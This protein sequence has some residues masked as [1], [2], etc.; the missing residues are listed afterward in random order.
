MTRATLISLCAIVLAGATSAA[1]QLVPPAEN[2]RAIVDDAPSGSRTPAPAMLAQSQAQAPRVAVGV[3][4]RRGTFVGYVD[5]A[6]IQSNVRIRFDAA[7]GNTVPDRAEFFYAKCSCYR[8]LPPDHPGFDPDAP[9]PGP[10]AADDIRF[11]QLYL[12]GGDLLLEDTS[13]SVLELLYLEG[14]L[15][16]GRSHTHSFSRST[17]V[18]FHLIFQHLNFVVGSNDTRQVL[19]KL[20]YSTVLVNVN[21]CTGSPF[22]LFHFPFDYKRRVNTQVHSVRLQVLQMVDTIL[23]THQVI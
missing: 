21:L 4:R 16:T 14:R 11:Q 9:G 2:G 22:K 8:G 19:T 18:Q 1:A 10:G 6:L 3:R 12:E 23:H 7:T 15:L 13:S 5:D 20:F 17:C